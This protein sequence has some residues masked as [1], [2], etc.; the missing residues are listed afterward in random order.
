MP[1]NMFLTTC[2]GERNKLR[3]VKRIRSS[4]KKGVRR[5]KVVTLFE[6]H[7]KKLTV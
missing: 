7:V 6:L 2:G 5:V 4:I 3:V 1:S